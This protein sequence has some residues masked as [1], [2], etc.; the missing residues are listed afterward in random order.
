MSM[1]YWGIYG[2]GLKVSLEIFDPKKI[3]TLWFEEEDAITQAELENNYDTEDIIS[4]ILDKNP[5]EHLTYVSTGMSDIQATYLYISA[6]LPWN[7]TPGYAQLTEETIKDLIIETIRP[8]VKDIV[9]LDQERDNID[10]ISSYG[11]G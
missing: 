5:N 2:Y 4:E 3:S 10:V 8:Y 1:D 11:C 9:D 6:Q 7:I